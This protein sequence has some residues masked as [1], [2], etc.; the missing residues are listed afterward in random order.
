M[1]VQLIVSFERAMGT[2]VVRDE[3]SSTIRGTC[4]AGLTCVNARRAGRVAA[5]HGDLKKLTPC[6][7]LELQCEAL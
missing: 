1:K 6:I 5:Q 7:G 3:G 2:G 4:D